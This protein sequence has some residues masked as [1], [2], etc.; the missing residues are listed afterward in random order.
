MYIAEEQWKNEK[1]I[2]VFQI[3]AFDFFAGNSP[4]CDE[5]PCHW[6]SMR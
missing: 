6:E 2:L 1:K 3:I 4:Y 5:N